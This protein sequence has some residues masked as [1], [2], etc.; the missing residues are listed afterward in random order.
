[1]TS[2]ALVFFA[3]LRRLTAVAAT[4]FLLAASGCWAEALKVDEVAPGVFVHAGRV[5]L[6]SPA[7]GG[8]ISNCGFVIGREAVAVID[9][10]GSE[11]VGAE[12]RAAIRSRTDKPV[13]YVVLTH[14]HPDHV[15]GAAAFA[16]DHPAYVAHH[17]LARALAARAERYV[18]AN[19]EL[20][21]EAAFAGSRI[22]MPTVEVSERLDLDLGERKLELRAWP[23]AHTDNDLTVWDQ[24]TGTLFLGDLLFSRHVPALDGSLRGWLKVMTELEAIPA[25]RVVP[26]HGPAAMDWPAALAPQRRYLTRIAEDVRADIKAGRTL[27]EAARTAGLSE[28]D[29]WALFEDFNARNVSAAFAELEWE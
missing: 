16:D 14:M 19:R 15:L 29:A 17:K 8:D 23:T 3:S 11:A 28:K 4:L 24:T 12:L 6:Y 7:V 1:M 22:V 5:A 13:R 27:A 25:R 2:G 9:S 26:G 18:A 21:G 10:C 20:M